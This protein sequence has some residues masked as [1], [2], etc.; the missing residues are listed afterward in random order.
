[1]PRAP[2]ARRPTSTA[3][4]R[5]AAGEAV[6]TL[7][8]ARFAPLLDPDADAELEALARVD[9]AP[10]PGP[11]PGKVRKDRR[12]TG[13]Q[14]Q[15][16]RE[17]ASAAWAAQ[18]EAR[19]RAEREAARARDELAERE[20]VRARR[21]GRCQ[22][23]FWIVRPGVA[24]CDCGLTWNRAPRGVPVGGFLLFFPRFTG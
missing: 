18:C 4:M 3:M 14:R 1:M 8:L 16:A 5:G 19:R 22:H 24:R 12:W 20:R 9:S 11:C 17:R 7:S 15:R 13:E 23:R 21:L 6:R 10:R 2:R